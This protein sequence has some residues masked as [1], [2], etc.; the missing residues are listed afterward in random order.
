MKSLNEEPG[1]CGQHGVMQ[2]QRYEDARSVVFVLATLSFDKNEPFS[3]NKATNMFI[4][5]FVA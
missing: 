3:R 5:I 2:E 4:K 1:E